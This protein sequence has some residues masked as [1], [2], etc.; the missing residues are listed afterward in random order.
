[1]AQLNMV[2]KGLLLSDFTIDELALMI[3][4]DPSR[5]KIHVKSAGFKPVLTT[6]LDGES[7]LFKEI[8]F[9]VLWTRPESIPPFK[10]ILE[11][12]NPPLD[13]ILK[14][15]DTLAEAILNRCK[16]LRYAFVMAWTLS[17][18][19]R[20]RG[21]L[22]LKS[23]G[24]HHTLLQMNLRMAQRLQDASNCYI[25]NTPSWIAEIGAEAFSHKSW[26]MGKIPFHP[27][28][29]ERAVREIKASIRTILGLSRKVI[30]VDLDDTLW[31]GIVGDVGWEALRLGGND[32][33]G[34]AFQDFQ[35]GLKAMTWKGILLAIASKNEE[36]VALEAIAKH[37]EMILKSEDFAV[38]RINWEDK[39]V[40]IVQIAD[41]L[42]V[43]LDS[44]VFIDDSAAERDRVREALPDV[45]VPDW[46]V[47]KTRYP[48]ALL[49]LDCFD[50]LST[51]R[52]DDAR[53]EMMAAEKKRQSSRE[54][55]PSLDEWLKSLEIKIE[56]QTLNEMNL[57]RAV[58][59]F[60][61][62]NQMNLSTR[63]LTK[64]EL[65]VWS[66]ESSHRFWTL[67]ITD[68]FGEYGLTGLLGIKIEDKKAILVDFILSCRVF[69]RQVEQAMFAFLVRWAKENG[70]A[71]IKALYLPTKKNQPT[72]R[73]L[74]SFRLTEKEENLFLWKTGDS[75]D[76]PEFIRWIDEDA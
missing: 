75:V 17:P 1:M 76:I 44:V 55:I 36:T 58:Q 60:N 68:R 48:S 25:L 12:E 3:K 40:N 57:E 35:R 37:P 19:I 9:T 15:V 70:I 51:T 50:T 73:F 28:V 54:K 20:G 53:T 47:D 49:Q 65:L 22:D 30:V 33:V 13:I 2:Q 24:V 43:G 26:Y 38:F 8:Q 67:R 16:N 63:R 29:F 64:D 5:P 62:T 74:Q 56:C 10:R 14:E 34:E 7:E 71:E 69:G 66:K 41:T 27:R 39:A 32:P 31:G 52:E 45:Y 4:N 23:G 21:L 59:L 61:K 18:T 42:N 72:L 11:N 46:P 6:L